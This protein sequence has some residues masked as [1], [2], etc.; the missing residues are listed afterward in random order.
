M[1]IGLFRD[2]CL[3]VG[4]CGVKDPGCEVVVDVPAPVQ[5]EIKQLEK[6]F[7]SLQKTLQAMYERGKNGTIQV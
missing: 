3:I 7:W 5:R 2:E 1:K 6:V 4:S